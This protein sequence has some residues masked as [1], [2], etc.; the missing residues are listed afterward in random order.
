MGMEGT[1]QI[2]VGL[3]RVCQKSEDSYRVKGFAGR[4]GDE[5]RGKKDKRDREVR[6]MQ[7]RTLKV[8]RAP[9]VHDE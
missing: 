9:L 6:R 5:R 4:I 3:C 7:D 8:F 2:P 1:W